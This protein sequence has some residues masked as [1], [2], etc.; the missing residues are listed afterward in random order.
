MYESM[1][2]LTQHWW[3]NARRTLQQALP[4]GRGWLFTLSRL[5]SL[6]TG[7]VHHY[8]IHGTIWFPPPNLSA[9]AKFST[10]EAKQILCCYTKTC[11][12][13]LPSDE[14]PAVFIN[15]DA[16]TPILDLL[17]VWGVPKSQNHLF[18]PNMSPLLKLMMLLGLWEHFCPR[19]NLSQEFT[20]DTQGMDMG[21][22]C[23]GLAVLRIHG[24]GGAKQAATIH[25]R[26]GEPWLGLSV[27]TQEKKK[28]SGEKP[29]SSA[30]GIR[31][32]C[33]IRWIQVNEKLR[34]DFISADNKTS[35]SHS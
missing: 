8:N 14:I 24:H 25:G 30:E 2:A 12:C 16:A 18:S 9:E 10:E 4:A 19:A 17:N 32:Y 6:P 35:A 29:L 28:K 23:Q 20:P 26:A 27:L 3:V 1:S 13:W 34:P 11:S 22:S 31:I 15:G 33:H 21:R 7:L 5:H